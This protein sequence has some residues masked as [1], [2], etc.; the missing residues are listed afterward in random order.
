MIRAVRREHVEENVGREG[1]IADGQVAG[2]AVQQRLPGLP[3]THPAAQLGNL[4]GTGGGE[5]LHDPAEA[6]GVEQGPIG[7]QGRRVLVRV[8]DDTDDPILGAEVY[9]LMT[10]DRV[11][12]QP[13]ARPGWR[14]IASFDR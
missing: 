11:W 6:L 7:D 4:D 10:G 5:P 1:G 9:E 12:E 2:D 3:V 14:G 13:G 8:G